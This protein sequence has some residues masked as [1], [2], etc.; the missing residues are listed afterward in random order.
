MRLNFDRLSLLSPFSVQQFF[1][2]ADV[3]SNLTL[4]R[5]EFYM[6]ITNALTNPEAIS[7]ILDSASKSDDEDAEGR[8]L[9]ELIDLNRDGQLTRME[10]NAG[11]KTL[12]KAG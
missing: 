2:A 7:A 6:G 1:L 12:K 11:L 10:I 5:D 9:F 4:T 3:D 8:L